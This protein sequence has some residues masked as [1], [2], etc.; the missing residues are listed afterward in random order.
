MKKL[1]LSL[2]VVSI[3]TSCKN[4]KQTETSINLEE[5]EE[6]IYLKGE[7]VHYGD[8]AVLQTQNDIYGVIVTDKMLELNKQAG[9]YKKADTDM[10]QVE[11]RGKVSNENHDKILWENK[12]EIVEI[13]SVSPPE[14]EEENNI[15]KLGEK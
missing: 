9:Q 6:L 12:L 3:L 10:V 7:F 8:A 1:F 11:V 15:V 2:L 5:N 14:E 13:L 4:E